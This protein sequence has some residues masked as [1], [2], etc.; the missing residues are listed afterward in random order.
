MTGYTKIANGK[1]DDYFLSLQAYCNYNLNKTDNKEPESCLDAECLLVYWT[2]NDLGNIPNFNPLVHRKDGRFSLAAMLAKFTN[3]SEYKVKKCIT[4]LKKDGFIKTFRYPVGK[5]NQFATEYEVSAQKR[6]CVD[7]VINLTAQKGRDRAQKA[8]GR[9][10]FVPS[11][12][13]KYIKVSRNI[14][15]GSDLSALAKFLYMLIVRAA[16]LEQSSKEFVLTKALLQKWTGFGRRKF[17]RLWSE[18]KAKGYLLV[19]QI[20][21]HRIEWEYE[22]YDVPNEAAKNYYIEFKNRKQEQY[23]DS[24]YHKKSRDNKTEREIDTPTKTSAQGSLERNVSKYKDVTVADIKEKIGYDE[25]L[26]NGQIGMIS[27][28]PLT[29]D[30]A[31]ALEPTRVTAKEVN[32]LIRAM[33]SV[34][35]STKKEYNID[36]AAVPLENVQ[37]TLETINGEDFKEC[38]IR[39]KSAQERTEILHPIPYRIAVLY[40]TIHKNH[41]NA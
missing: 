8:N 32:D 15:M 24:L 30:I 1:Q 13:S 21:N 26:P 6:D 11:A 35:T 3:L 28:N 12:P 23:Y 9:I 4:K 37:R 40:R 16:K 25:I 19:R 36:G 29:A 27:V 33:R 34:F 38:C 17:D 41:K 31:D 10:I 7:R 22:F 20:H 18:L 14:T 39:V 5:E 2:L